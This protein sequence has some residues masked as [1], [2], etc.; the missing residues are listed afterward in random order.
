[1]KSLFSS[2]IQR[3]Q[4]TEVEI[5]CPRRKMVIVGDGECGKTCLVSRMSTGSFTDVGY[6]PTVFETELVT[7]NTGEEKVE[8]VIH[9]TAGQEDYDRLRPFSY[10][11]IDVVL[12]CFS[13]ADSDTLV[14][15]AENWSPEIRYY[16]G[17]APV[18]LVGNKKDLRD[19]PEGETDGELSGFKTP[20]SGSSGSLLSTEEKE[21]FQS[22]SSIPDELESQLASD[23]PS[24]HASTTTGKSSTITSSKK[25]YRRG[26]PVKHS[27]GALMAR[28]IGAIAYFETSA[29]D[30]ENTEELLLATTKAAILGNKKAKKFK[31][32]KA[33][34][35]KWT[36]TTIHS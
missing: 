17:G 16:C 25:V 18:I 7:V 33:T 20:S 1:M 35:A 28:R 24:S 26:A 31:P 13:L 15:V 22:T 19:R 21:K 32:L 14:N 27:D 34:L 3:Q 30:G 2:C 9:D 5:R 4:S 6:I 11:D 10:A 12:V 8:L 29:L 36:S 23:E